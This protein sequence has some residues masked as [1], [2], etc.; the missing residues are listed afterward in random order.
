MTTNPKIVENLDTINQ[1]VGKYRWTICALVF[2]ATTVNYIDRQVISLLKSD[3]TREFNWND[4]DYA[5]I[6][7]AFKIAYAL[8]MVFS[9]RVID[10]VGTK[11]GYFLATFFWSLAA[12]GHALVNSTFNL[13][14]D[15]LTEL[16]SVVAT[17]LI[18]GY[19]FLNAAHAA[20]KVSPEIPTQFSISAIP[21]TITIIASCL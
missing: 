1:T 4:G 11:M 10:K 18:F 20:S 13:L 17:L 14:C 12:V 15:E 9:G 21:A 7:I 5:D 19:A 16:R 3:L 8:G 2:F 6:E